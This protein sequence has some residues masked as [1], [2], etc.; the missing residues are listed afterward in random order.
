MVLVGSQ[1][2]SS[3]FLRNCLFKIRLQGSIRLL[4]RNLTS[5]NTCHGSR[6]SATLTSW[7]PTW[8]AAS[9]RNRYRSSSSMSVSAKSRTRLSVPCSAA[10]RLAA[11]Q[12]PTPPL[13]MTT[14]CTYSTL[15]VLPPS[16][17]S[18]SC[19]VPDTAPPSALYAL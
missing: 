1:F 14:C 9:S 13:N 5:K 4:P 18:T 19:V 15:P 8:A 7:P 16:P 11:A 6:P 10:T 3:H 17:L 12:E 2:C